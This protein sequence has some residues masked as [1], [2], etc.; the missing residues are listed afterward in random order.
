MNSPLLIKIWAFRLLIPAVL[1]LSLSSCV[2]QTY[3]YKPTTINVALF[4][5]KGDFQVGLGASDLSGFN[6]AYAFTD[7]F[8]FGLG[9][10]SLKL[11]D[12][13][14]VFDN[15]GTYK[16]EAEYI[17]NQTDY[18][19]AF[20][21]FNNFDK[22]NLRYEVQLGFGS[23]ERSEEM[24]SDFDLSNTIYDFEKRRTPIYNRFFI[25][26]AL[27]KNGKYFDWSF[28]ARLQAIN[29]RDLKY[30]FPSPGLDNYSDI[31]IEPT[32]TLRGGYKYIK[33][34]F[35]IGSRFASSNGPYDYIP[36]HVGIGL[37]VPINRHTINKR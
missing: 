26:P 6:A 24:K 7:H 27:G 9:F 30:Q 19:L 2:T 25:Q 20:I 33:A 31:V 1:A 34:M 23:S 21:Y 12:T 3:R 29:Y 32:L 8:G 22:G 28:G 15:M 5:Q 36:L 14:E 4:E 35:Q 11:I 10:S 37:V 18:E 17:D 16:G 13:L